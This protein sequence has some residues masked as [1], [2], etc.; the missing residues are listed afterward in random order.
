MT[1]TTV[2]DEAPLVV[3]MAENGDIEPIGS[4]WKRASDTG[5]PF[6]VFTCFPYK[7]CFHITRLENGE[8]WSLYVTGDIWHKA[9]A[10]D[11]NLEP[12]EEYDDDYGYD[13]G[14][15]AVIKKLFTETTLAD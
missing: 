13:E 15:N 5:L 7:V 8:A 14:I 9:A 1:T 3:K 11:S 2:W 10:I 12:S 6:Q 4:G